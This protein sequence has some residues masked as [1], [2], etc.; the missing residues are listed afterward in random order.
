MLYEEFIQDILDTRGR[1]NCVGYHEKHHILPRCCGGIDEEENLIDLYA[2]EHFIAHKLLAEE[3]KDNYKLLFAWSAMAFPNSTYQSRENELTPEEYENL[4]IAVS[5]AMKEHPTTTPESSKKMVET[6]KRNGSYEK[7]W[8]KGLNKEND[9]RVASFGKKVSEKRKKMFAEGKLKK[10][11]G[12]KNGM[13]GKHY[14]WFNNGVEQCMCL[15]CPEGWVKGRLTYKRKEY[16]KETRD[17]MARLASERFKG[18][19]PWNKKKHT[20]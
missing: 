13:Y 2:N 8:C 17:K 18:K 16:S 19:E 15:E 7:P 10:P 4:R 12:E 11:A 5:I 9:D 6:R 1:F 3:N 14:H 20:V